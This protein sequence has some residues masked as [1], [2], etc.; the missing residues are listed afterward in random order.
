MVRLVDL[1]TGESRELGRHKAPA[2]F[3]TFSPDGRYLFTGGWEREL[4]CWDVRAMRRAFT[5]EEESYGMQVRADGRQC[6]ILRALGVRVQLHAFEP[7]ALHR[8]FVG[9]LGGNPNHAAFSPDG[10]WLA[11]SGSGQRLAVWD[12]TGNGPAALLKESAV[13]HVDFAPSGEL[14][15]SRIGDCSRWRIRP[16]TNGLEPELQQLELATPAGFSSLCL[17][18]NG[19]VLNGTRG[20]KAVSFDEMVTGQGTWKPTADGRVAASPDGRW[21]GLHRRYT[22]D[23]YVY[24]LPGL[25]RV[26]KLTNESRVRDFEFSPRGDELAVGTATGVEF[27]STTTWQRTRQLTNFNSVLYSP[28]GRT[29]W[30]SSGLRAAGLYD[31]RTTE[32]LLPLPANTIPLALSP[33]RRH[34]A[35]SLNARHIQ[36]WDLAEVRQRLREFGLDWE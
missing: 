31:A 4:I 23:L 12:L 6:A 11:A 20:S 18:S 24:R 28:D 14:F 32:L 35:A 33:D 15:S 1:A 21:L 25:E 22:S 27:W 9:D 7:P 34:L 26:A 16:G 19:V 5:I 10:R 2:V 29:F 30:L 13:A 8:E 17:I 36:V 3:T